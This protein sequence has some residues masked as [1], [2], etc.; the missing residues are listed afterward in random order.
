MKLFHC[1]VVFFCG[2]FGKKLFFVF[3]ELKPIELVFLDAEIVAVYLSEV[4][5]LDVEEATS[6]D[7]WNLSVFLP[8]PRKILVLS[9][10]CRDQSTQFESYVHLK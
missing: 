3:L 4:I 6:R 2:N 1:F 10:I 7:K 9:R 8:I 5:D